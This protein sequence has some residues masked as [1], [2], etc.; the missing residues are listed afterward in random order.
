MGTS[1]LILMVGEGRG[2]G[3]IDFDPNKGTPLKRR[4]QAAAPYL[5][6]P[7]SLRNQKPISKERAAFR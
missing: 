1:N 6:L 3:I 4:E 7:A 2:K 5:Q